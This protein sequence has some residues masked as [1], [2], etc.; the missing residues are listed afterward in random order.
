MIGSTRLVEMTEQKLRGKPID[1]DELSRILEPWQGTIDSIVLG[2]THF[3]LIKKEIQAV[4]KHSVNVVDS[5]KAIARRVALLLE[6]P[7][8]VF[9][10]T[11][12][13]KNVTYSS[14][15]TYDAAALNKSLNEM[16]LDAIQDLNYPHF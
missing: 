2:C 13:I 8:D 6:L 7:T 9:S 14:A 1:M 12:T 3:P 10:S 4:L 15:A 11:N 16:Q 5:G